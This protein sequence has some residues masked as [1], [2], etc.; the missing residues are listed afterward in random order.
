M[1]R[2]LPVIAVGLLVS[3]CQFIGKA[4]KRDAGPSAERNYQ[5]AAF[6]RIEVAGP[7]DVTVT[8]GGQ[9]GVTAQGGA[10]FLDETEVAVVDG[11]LRIR[12]KKKN[13]NWSWSDD[14]SKVRFQVNGAALRGAAIAGSGD[15]RIDRVAGNAFKGEVAGSGNLEVAA[16]EA[17]AISFAVAGSGEVRAG[18]KAQT[19]DIEIAGSGDVDTGGLEAATA[20]VSIAGSGNVRAR[21]TGTVD[22]SIMGSGDVE[23]TGGAKCNVSK[24]GSGNVRCS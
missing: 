22:V 16:A 4:E 15:I 3:A 20:N 13:I 21:A 6:D 1:K 14:D 7:Y 8:S 11:V 10:N 12:P 5:V 9:A 23:V 17:N 24:Q 19:L 18:G 2:L